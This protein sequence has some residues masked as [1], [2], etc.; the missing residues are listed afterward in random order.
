[1][2]GLAMMTS[3]YWPATAI[4]L[5]GLWLWSAATWTSPDIPEGWK[6]VDLEQ[7]ERL[8]RDGSLDYHRD[9][10]AT[11]LT[12]VGEKTRFIVLPESA[13]G[14]WTPTLAKLWSQGLR[15]SALTVIAGA[16]VIDPGG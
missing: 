12:D 15:G 3:R 2:A 10:I 6:G 13:L 5:G 4:V 9:L 11:V 16:D 8:G 7:G 1:T 14:F